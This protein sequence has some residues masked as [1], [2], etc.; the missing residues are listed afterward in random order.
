MGVDGEGGGDRGEEEG[1]GVKGMG[2]E[3]GGGPTLHLTKSHKIMNEKTH[4]YPKAADL[5]SLFRTPLPLLL[6]TLPRSNVLY[7]PEKAKIEMI[8]TKSI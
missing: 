2:V 6:L 4:T 7:T 1:E 8:S 5:P 3:G